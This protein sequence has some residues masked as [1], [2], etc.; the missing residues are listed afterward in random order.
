M[1]VNLVT[2]FWFR[3]FEEIK[4]ASGHRFGKPFAGIS[5]LGYHSSRCC[6]LHVAVPIDSIHRTDLLRKSAF[7]FPCNFD[8]KK[9]K[10]TPLFIDRIYSETIIHQK[11]IYMNINEKNKIYSLLFFFFFRSGD[12]ICLHLFAC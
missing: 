6:G 12:F 5:M 10:T 8:M 2:V 1:C 11:Y 3:R 4:S 7:T 9:M